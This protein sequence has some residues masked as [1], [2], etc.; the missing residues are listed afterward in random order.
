[1]TKTQ[2]N[3]KKGICI[4]FEGIAGCGKSTQTKK[5]LKFLENKFPSRKVVLTFEPGGTEIANNIRKAVQGTSYEEEMDPICETYLYAASRAQSLRKVV[6]PVLDGGGIVI[7]DRSYVTSLAYQGIIRGLGLQKV[8]NINKSAIQDTRVNGV[9]YMDIK[10]KNAVSRMLD[11]DGDKW[12]KEG[13]E[14]YNRVKKAYKRVFRT[15]D[16]KNKV[17][18]VDSNGSVD[19]VFDNVKEAA[20]DII[21]RS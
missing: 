5:L 13:E 16:L 21:K 11:Q 6:N 20:L 14:L 12:E 18:V 7:M 15:K 1:M 3:K 8:L 17:W 2:N 19:N 10:V 4:I 9:I